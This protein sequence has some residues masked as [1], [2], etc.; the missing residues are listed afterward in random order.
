MCTLQFTAYSPFCYL[1]IIISRRSD[2]H[3]NRESILIL[4]MCCIIINIRAHRGVGGTEGGE[5]HYHES[6]LARFLSRPNRHRF[7]RASGRVATTSSSF[8][9]TI[10]TLFAWP[11]GSISI[12]FAN[13][14][15]RRLRRAGEN[16][17]REEFRSR[18]SAKELKPR[19]NNHEARSLSGELTRPTIAR[20]REHGPNIFTYFPS[21]RLLDHFVRGMASLASVTRARHLRDRENKYP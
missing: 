6:V 14:D 20:G 13:G 5:A 1:D 3:A 8:A 15:A 19:M 4:E 21:R 16:D 7:E 18:V 10:R 11:H 9:R 12:A 2:A 17:G